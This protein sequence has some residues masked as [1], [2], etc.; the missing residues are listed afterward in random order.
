[1]TAVQRSFKHSHSLAPLRINQCQVVVRSLGRPWTAV[2]NLFFVTLAPRPGSAHQSITFRS[3]ALSDT[4]RG[5]ETQR[6]GTASVAAT[7]SREASIPDSESAPTG[8]TALSAPLWTAPSRWGHRK[9]FPSHTVEFPSPRRA[10]ILARGPASESTP[11]ATEAPLP[12]S[13]LHASTP[14]TEESV[15]FRE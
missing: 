1:M 10:L 4:L 7:S 8:S 14:H 2:V 15:K 11:P 9:S 13:L 3:A 5:G 12:P 6:E